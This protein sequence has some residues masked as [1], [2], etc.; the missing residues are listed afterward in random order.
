KPPP[1]LGDPRATA[2]NELEQHQ[3]CCCPSPSIPDQERNT[4]MATTEAGKRIS[5]RNALKHGIL[6]PVLV[7]EGVEKEE[8]WQ[9]H[10]QSLLDDLQPEGATEERLVEEIARTFWRLDRVARYEHAVLSRQLEAA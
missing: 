10:R 2:D 7:L 4:Q 8:D 1:L 3:S 6:S 5:S 9:R